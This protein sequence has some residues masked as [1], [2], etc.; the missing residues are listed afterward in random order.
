M[1]IIA[2]LFIDFWSRRRDRIFWLWL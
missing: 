2:S 1:K